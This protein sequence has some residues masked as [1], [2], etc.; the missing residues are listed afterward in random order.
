MMWYKYT[1][2]YIYIYNNKKSY[3]Y[4]KHVLEKYYQDMF[5]KPNITTCFEK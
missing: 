3:I 4:K 2:L 1:I 5:G